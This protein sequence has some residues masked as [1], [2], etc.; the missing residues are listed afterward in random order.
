MYSTNK[1]ERERD[2]CVR[3]LT[4]LLILLVQLIVQYY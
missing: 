1:R 4:P 3:A 2:E